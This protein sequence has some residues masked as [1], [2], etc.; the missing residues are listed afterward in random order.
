MSQENERLLHDALTLWSS[1]KVFKWIMSQNESPEDVYLAEELAKYKAN[2]N[3]LVNLSLSGNPIVILYSLFALSKMQSRNILSLC[4]KLKNDSRI[5]K[6]RVENTVAE[7]S[8]GNVA[9]MI[10]K[11]MVVNLIQDLENSFYELLKKGKS[12]ELTDKELIKEIEHLIVANQDGVWQEMP[13]ELKGNID[14]FLGKLR[15]VVD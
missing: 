9:E 8:V 2:E 15:M 5:V 10:K 12:K 7:R 1:T 6:V 14:T 3:A 11:N 4:D 13:A